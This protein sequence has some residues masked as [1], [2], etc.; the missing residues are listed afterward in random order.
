MRVLKA[1]LYLLQ[2][3]F[4]QLERFAIWSNL[5]KHRVGPSGSVAEH[6]LALYLIPLQNKAV[7]SCLGETVVQG[8][9]PSGPRI[10]FFS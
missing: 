1:V 10:S 3:L 4:S 5:R 2:T 7:G 6:Y 9:C 8:N